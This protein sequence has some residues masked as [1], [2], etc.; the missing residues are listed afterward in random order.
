LSL[1]VSI[2]NFVTRV[3]A[4]FWRLSSNIYVWGAD[5]FRYLPLTNMSFILCF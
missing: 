2:F 1:E 3:G 5:V 4:R